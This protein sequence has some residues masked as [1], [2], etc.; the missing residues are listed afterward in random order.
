MQPRA[1]LLGHEC[2]SAPDEDR[3]RLWLIDN[4]ATSPDVSGG[5][6]WTTQGIEP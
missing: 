5:M 3:T 6:K 1:S 2:V 4:Q